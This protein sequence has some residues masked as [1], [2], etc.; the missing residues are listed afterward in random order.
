MT[1]AATVTST[2]AT[3]PRAAVR[4]RKT[5][6][7]EGSSKPIMRMMAS[8]PWAAP[9]P[10]TMPTAEATRPTRRA[11]ASTDVTR[12]RRLA[13]TARSR[14]SSRVRWATRIE[15]VLKMMKAPTRRATAANMSRAVVRKPRA[16]VHDSCASR[17]A[18]S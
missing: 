18:W 3:R 13:P 8:R 6:G 11:S 4:P 1:A 9:R 14:P 7:A 10:R 17:A 16:L 12:W 2:P 5:T 15:K